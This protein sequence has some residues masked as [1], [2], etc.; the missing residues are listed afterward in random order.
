MKAWWL[1]GTPES[2]IPLIHEQ[3]EDGIEALKPIYFRALVGGSS[4]A[5]ASLKRFSGLDRGQGQ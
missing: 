5:L 1:A 4:W 3:N 2:P